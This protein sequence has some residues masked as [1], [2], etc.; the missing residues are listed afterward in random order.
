VSGRLPP[1]IDLETTELPP[2][3]VPGGVIEGSRF[4][5][6]QQLRVV[7][8]VDLRVRTNPNVEANQLGAAPI[9][10]FVAILAGPVNNGCCE[11]WQVKTAG[12]LI[13]WV[14]AIIDGVPSLSP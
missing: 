7:T 8:A 6:G 1:P 3:F 9:G 10:S 2:N 12:G 11:W 5:P 13:G 4:T 14:A